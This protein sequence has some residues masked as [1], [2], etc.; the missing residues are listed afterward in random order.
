MGIQ[1]IKGVEVGDGFLTTKRPGSQAHDELE[2]GPDGFRRGTATVPEA[3]KAE[4]R[5]AGRCG[6]VPE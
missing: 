2:V 6:C 4:C 3:P 1:A 5:P